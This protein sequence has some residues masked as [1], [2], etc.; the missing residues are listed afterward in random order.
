[1]Y[2]EPEIIH[3]LDHLLPFPYEC[4]DYEQ[5]PSIERPHQY[6]LRQNEEV[7]DTHYDDILD[8]VVPLENPNDEQNGN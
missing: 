4:I 6:D 5:Y 3:I 7:L 8:W 1:M 2:L